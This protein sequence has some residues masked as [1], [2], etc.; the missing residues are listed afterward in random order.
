MPIL[1]LAQT[2]ALRGGRVGSSW[3]QAQTRLLRWKRKCKCVWGGQPTRFGPDLGLQWPMWPMWIMGEKQGHP[4]LRNAKEIAQRLLASVR[5]QVKGFRSAMQLYACSSSGSCGW[6][7]SWIRRILWI[8][9]LTFRRRDH[10]R[11]A[12]WWH[13]N[14]MG[15]GAEAIWVPVLSH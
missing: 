14:S 9:W 1:R 10:G 13:R 2:R 6:Y 11:L 8:L 15:H 7:C 4:T 12:F 3:R 5:A